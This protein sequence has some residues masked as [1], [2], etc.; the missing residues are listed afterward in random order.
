M[1]SFLCTVLCILIFHGAVSAQ[2]SAGMKITEVDITQFP[3]VVLNLQIRKPANSNVT[4]SA[5]NVQLDE[6]G[7]AQLVEYLEC[8]QDSSIRLSIA[9]LLDRSGSMARD[10][11]NQPDPDS[12]K[13]REAKKAITAFFDLLD[14]RDEAAIFSFTTVGFFLNHVFTVEHDFTADVVSLKNALVPIVAEGGTRLWDAVIDAVDLLKVRT[15]RKALIVVTDGIDRGIFSTRDEAIRAAVNEGIPVYPIG[16]GG[17]VDA[18]ALSGLASATGGKLYLSPSGVDL[19]S[20]FAQLGAELL[21]DDCIL[22]YTSSNPC[23]DGSRRDVELTLTGLGF[24]AE[25]DTFYTVQSMLNP[26]SLVVENGVTA[27]SRDTLVLPVNVLEQFSTSQPLSY[28]MT[29]RYDASLMQYIDVNVQ[30]TMSA[31]RLVDVTETI[32]GQLDI[33]LDN[34]QPLFPSGTLFELLF[35]SFS[36]SSDTETRVE[37]ENGVVTSL[38]PMAVSMSGGTLSIAACEETFALR[39]GSFVVGENGTV[40]IPVSLR[41]ALLPDA[42]YDLRLLLGEAPPSLMLEDVITVGTLSEGGGLLLQPSPQGLG[43][44]VKLRGTATDDSTV[45]ILRYRA[46]SS[47]DVQKIP[48]SLLIEQIESGCRIAAQIEQPLI[49]IDGVCRPL[50]RRRQPVAMKVNNHPNP[51]T[52]ETTLRYTLPKDGDVSLSL[53]DTQ[54]RH[55]R[56]LLEAH[57]TAGSYEHRIETSS[58][59]PG[60]YLIILRSGEEHATHRMMCVH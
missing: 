44:D 32:P 7:V 38:C 43:I 40:D 15:G 56:T 60:D 31:G 20:I 34:F 37:I 41:P 8:P 9:V 29:V 18:G 22:R 23:L 51:V 36:R 35:V 27:V 24:A 42:E 16:L 3:T 19:Q 39:T 2:G 54:G 58:L 26:V 1:R 14:V 52:D 21:T 50:L 30:G 4:I 48:L 47:E 5:A 11:N 28:S 45:F 59:P 57:M 17:D 10:A 6:N 33:R 49:I 25:A 46:T 53:L 13:M 55:V 12:T